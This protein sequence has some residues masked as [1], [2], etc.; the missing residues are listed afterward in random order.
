VSYNLGYVVA[1]VSLT[2]KKKFLISFFIS[3]LTELSLNRML[4]SFRVYVGLLLF[5]YVV[6]EDQP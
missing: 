6:I 4:F 5:I 1:S 3:F 2:S